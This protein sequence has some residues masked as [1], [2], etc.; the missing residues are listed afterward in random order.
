MISARTRAFLNYSKKEGPH[1]HT[2]ASPNIQ[3]PN[4]LLFLNWNLRTVVCNLQMAER[5]Q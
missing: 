1:L 4:Y 3:S 5:K 2:N